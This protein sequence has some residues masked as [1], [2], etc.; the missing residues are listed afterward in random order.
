MT[1]DL[2]PAETT[3]PR[4]QPTTQGKSPSRK[5]ASWVRDMP[6]FGTFKPDKPDASYKLINPD[7][8]KTVLEGHSER[9]VKRIQGDMDYA[10]H[11]VLRLFRA[12][13]YDAARNQNRYRKTQI[14]YILL[15]GLAT[16]FGA[17]Q[18]YTLA[19]NPRLSPWFGLVETVV[20][21]STVFI[22][23][24]N[25]RRPPLRAWMSNRRIA[26]QLRREYFRFITNLPPYTDL[27]ADDRRAEL[28]KRAANINLGIEPTNS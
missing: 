5:R 25:A 3:A 4:P 14:F 1:Q 11:E 10:E 27:N 15:A 23:A 2:T 26:E 12:R 7:A 16:T 19:G 20:A 28:S 13:D 21:L 24:I 9:V 22:A 17:L 8:L 18:A 6:Q